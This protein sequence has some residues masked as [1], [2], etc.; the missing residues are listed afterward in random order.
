MTISVCEISGDLVRFH[1]KSVSA[2]HDAHCLAQQPGARPEAHRS[3]TI[4]VMNK[5]LIPL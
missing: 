3:I 4:R 1:V 2:S 5:L